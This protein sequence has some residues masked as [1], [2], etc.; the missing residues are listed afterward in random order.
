MIRTDDNRTNGLLGSA[1]TA[2]KAVHLL[3]GVLLLAGLF[4]GLPGVAQAQMLMCDE[5]CAINH[6]DSFSVAQSVLTVRGT[7]QDDTIVIYAG[8]AQAYPADAGA[9]ECEEV[10]AIWIEMTPGT[11][12]PW[13]CYVRNENIE[14]IVVDG[15]AGNDEIDATR[16][17]EDD[18]KLL[19]I[20]SDGDD[21]LFGGAGD[22]VIRGLGGND[23]IDAG[24]GNDGDRENDDPVDGGPG[25]D[26]ILGG[27]GDDYIRGGGGEAPDACLLEP[28]NR[29]TLVPGWYPSEL[30]DYFCDVIFGGA[31]NDL[32]FG[33]DGTNYIMAGPRSSDED[34]DQVVGG[35]VTDYIFG[36]DGSDVISGAAG[37]DLIAG[38]AG[39]DT[40]S[41]GGGFDILDY[42]W[43]G[44]GA[45]A[46]VDLANGVAIDTYD[47]PGTD[48]VAGFIAIRGSRSTDVLIGRA[49][50][51]TVIMGMYGGDRM[52]GG[53]GTDIIFGTPG[54][55]VIDAC[56]AEDDSTE[57]SEARACYEEEPVDHLIDTGDIVFGGDGSDTVRGWAGD[58]V[59]FGD[60][61]PL[62]SPVP[63][64]ATPMDANGN[65]I[66]DFLLGEPNPLS[67]AMPVNIEILDVRDLVPVLL[68]DPDTGE[69]T[70]KIL[71]VPPFYVGPGSPRVFPY[72]SDTVQGY[73]GDDIIV[74]GLGNDT[75][76]DPGGG[77]ANPYQVVDDQALL[78][79]GEPGADTIW[80]GLHIPLGK[81][82]FFFP[83]TAIELPDG[84][85]IGG[86]GNEIG[87]DLIYGCGG[88]DTIYGEN[89]MDAQDGSLS[90]VIPGPD[91]IWGDYDYDYLDRF[92]RPLSPTEDDGIWEIDP[93][94][95]S[96]L[97]I[98]ADV[99]YAGDS[100]SNMLEEYIYGGAGD[101]ILVGGMGPDVIQ[102]NAGNDYIYGGSR[103]G[104]NYRD[105]SP[106][107]TLDYSTAS[108]WRHEGVAVRLGGQTGDTTDTTRTF[109]MGRAYDG[110][111]GIDTIY[112][113]ENVI[114]SDFDD[115]IVGSGETRAN[116]AGQMGAYYSGYFYNS[117]SV[118]KVGSGMPRSV[119]GEYTNILLGRQ[120]NDVIMGRG[121]EDYIHGG[122][123]NDIICGDTDIHCDPL[124][125]NLTLPI[126]LFSE[127]LRAE[128]A[129]AGQDDMLYG[130]YGNDQIYGDG[131]NDHVY[132]GPGAD[133]LSGGLGTYDVLD[134]SEFTSLQ[135]VVINLRNEP[136]DLKQWEE[137]TVSD[138]SILP[139]LPSS[140]APLPLA[141]CSNVNTVLCANSAV[142]GGGYGD[143][144]AIPPI[145]PVPPAVDTLVNTPPNDPATPYFDESK[146]RF[147][148]VLGSYGNDVIF[149]HKTMAN[150]IVG[151]SGNDVLVGGDATAGLT[152]GLLYHNMIYGDAPEN[153]EAA[154]LAI[155]LAGA[156][157]TIQPGDDL[158]ESGSGDDKLDGGGN[159]YM[160]K[161]DFLS[162]AH[163]RGFVNVSLADTQPQNTRAGGR[164]TILRFENLIGSNYVGPTGGGDILTGNSLNNLILGKNGD[165]TLNGGPGNDTLMGGLGQDTADYQSCVNCIDPAEFSVSEDPSTGGYFVGNDGQ[166]GSDVL[167][168]IERVLGPA[169]P[170]ML[171]AVD[172]GDTGGLQVPAPQLK[173]L[174]G[175]LGD[176]Q[177]TE[178]GG[179]V[180][181]PFSANGGV[182]PYTAKWDPTTDTDP[183]LPSR[184]ITILTYT[185]GSF[186]ANQIQT[187]VASPVRTTTYRVTVTD[188]LGTVQTAFVKVRVAGAFS[189]FAGADRVITSGQQVVLRPTVTGGVAPYGFAWAVQGTGDGGFI[190]ATNI[191]AVTVAP[192]ETTTYVLTVTDSLGSIATDTVTVTVFS[193]D[194]SGN[195]TNTGD[196]GQ[197]GDGGTGG[198]TGGD[199]GT[200]PDTGGDGQNPP[201]DGQDG[202]GGNDSGEQG[203]TIRRVT[204]P[205][206]GSGVNL[207][208]VTISMLLLGAIKRREW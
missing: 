183:K 164:D 25:C 169:G 134:Y 157:S 91:Y 201:S 48:A 152:D 168:G 22:D 79:D 7:D 145:P 21:R 204:F 167:A 81:P 94:N 162:Y 57:A 132:G 159:P 135:S 69:Y 35:P 151:W 50:V 200:G 17:G 58:D 82:P 14:Q 142:D 155:V 30:P 54:N 120:G 187:A 104:S 114:G 41:G 85:L 44:G 95:P 24:P 154:I 111:G 98:Y 125:L 137:E 100:G 163:A 153:T 67:A 184:M 76:G 190:S 161:G 19:L 60:G 138:P 71:P 84:D 186:Q 129:A 49:R 124:F 141:P 165:D 115:V 73:L 86:G 207:T 143:T 205:I 45:G 77:I 178:P 37:N 56:G 66:P 93:T 46:S 136:V 109:N 53:I 99:I 119:S 64:I 88:A 107:D 10:E 2:R 5:D 131:G 121:G 150:I 42:M 83:P 18:P 51:G 12:A 80:G 43:D 130:G 206:C 105:F 170:I 112:G 177:V 31:G 175:V 182:P 194:I 40:L 144:S 208:L 188:S 149:G 148:V 75:L 70:Q 63:G 122:A 127:R 13:T 92:G 20:G 116:I 65:G 28:K 196:T 4:F 173:V 199:G 180:T 68:T 62:F 52:I 102:G 166:G 47:P 55:D 103:T 27:T 203:S 61:D 158:I 1:P 197:P 89:V 11:G 198:G 26:T 15:L 113:I 147:E 174:I 185:G 59:L 189:V 108:Q 160:G 78:V 72:G 123:G 34:D 97:A 192:L 117:V 172:D 126:A 101:D 128:Y 96:T 176:L 16:M 36:G 156:S 139:F 106:M 9:T 195:P 140:V 39:D 6:A 74:G 191:A 90:Y 87:Y 29:N 33:G 146:D 38:M 110:E 181:I 202:N 118:T 193:L 23:Y 133:V 8:S 3:T 171:D 179:Q 32:I